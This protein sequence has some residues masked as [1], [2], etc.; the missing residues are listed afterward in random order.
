METY[1]KFKG[2][3]EGNVAICNVSE[4]TKHSSKPNTMILPAEY[5]NELVKD[6]VTISKRDYNRLNKTGKIIFK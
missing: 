4:C 5:C 6:E 3:I 2:N 1:F